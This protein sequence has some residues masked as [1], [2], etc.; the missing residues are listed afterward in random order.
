[1]K[2]KWFYGIAAVL[3]LWGSAFSS[4]SAMIATGEAPIQATEEEARAEARKDA[5]RK[6]I[7]QE[8]GVHVTSHTET[9]MGMVIS[10]EIS[11]KS[12]GYV[13]INK[14]LKEWQSEGF[15]FM[16]LDATADSRK[17]Q[18]AAQDIKSRLQAIEDEN[19]S[20]S[21]I[22][23][24]VVERNAAGQYSFTEG[25]TVPYIA[26]KLK[27]AGFNAVANDDVTA[28]L[29]RHAADPNA[30][31]EARRIA[32]TTRTEENALLRGVLAT[33]EIRSH[34][35]GMKEA[36]V[37]AS[38]ELIGLD[39]NRVDAF[40]RYFT[41]VAPYDA[42]AE[43]K[44]RDLATR[45]AVEELGR[46]ALE[47]VQSEMRSGNQVIKT[48]VIFAGLSDYAA[49]EQLIK[50]G[51]AAAQCRIIRASRTDA[52]TMKVFLSTNAYN[53]MASLASAIQAQIPGL[54]SGIEDAAS[55]GSSKLSFT[56]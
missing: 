36:V 25:D 3:M 19:T 22:Q 18:V 5:L 41:A 29:V 21:G 46:Q 32:R 54:E 8:V 37:K 56:F 24:A 39:S 35:D 49:Q 11:A 15:Y 16:Q 1:M 53:D 55:L 31:V 7:E 44:A 52:S 4:A 48:T 26:E 34:T 45:A 47:T 10:D 43:R 42:D 51:L 50:Q 9:S 27:L 30:G 20:R 6:V 28:Y 40:S 12:D 2:K 23:I 13:V 14:V 17:I 33:E 38:F